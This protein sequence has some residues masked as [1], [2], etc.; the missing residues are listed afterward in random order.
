MRKK[1]LAAGVFL[2]LAASVM[3][4]EIDFSDFDDSLMESMDDAIKELD[5]NVGGQEANVA[6]ELAV[7]LGDEVPDVGVAE[8]R[9]QALRFHGGRRRRPAI[10]R[11]GPVGLEALDRDRHHALGVNRG[12]GPE[13]VPLG[14]A[15]ACA[16][17]SA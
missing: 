13:G 1:W 14:H 2:T 3:A 8:Q 15:A 4:A 5:S 11:E 7:V 6:D 9:R 10:G 16:A 12:G 17:Q